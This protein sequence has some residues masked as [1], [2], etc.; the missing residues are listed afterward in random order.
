MASVTEAQAAE[1]LLDLDAL[2]E[3]GRFLQGDFAH[4]AEGRRVSA[5]DDA[6]ACFCVVGG[7][8]RCVGQRATPRTDEAAAIYTTAAQ[9]M[10]DVLVEQGAF[11]TPPPRVAQDADELAIA[12]L[13]VWSDAE[14]RTEADAR[15]LAR[16][17][18][19][20]LNAEVR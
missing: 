11:R 8:L 2:L 10:V 7:L 20:A 3:G 13:V 16:D 19:A 5:L 9:A 6:A 15:Q 12:S 1:A 18:A 17:A 4:D 14:E